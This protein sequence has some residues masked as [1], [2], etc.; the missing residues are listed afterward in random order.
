MGN[1]RL[2][3]L[4]LRDRNGQRK[5]L[6]QTEREVFRMNIQKLPPK[7][8]AF[9]LVL[10]YTGCRISEALALTSDSL[11][12]SDGIIVFETL[13]RRRSGVYRVIPVPET[14]SGV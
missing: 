2:E 10:Y 14:V 9:C 5:Y 4:I 1:K 13:K 8:R 6:N 7:Q 3:P 12:F 11:D